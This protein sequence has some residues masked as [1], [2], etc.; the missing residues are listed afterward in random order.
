[1]MMKQVSDMDALNSHQAKSLRNAAR[2]T[3][4]GEIGGEEEM[5]AFVEATAVGVKVYNARAVHEAGV[6]LARGPEAM[7]TQKVIYPV[8]LGTGKSDKGHYNILQYRSADGK[9]TSVFD[10]KD[11]LL[12]EAAEAFVRGQWSKAASSPAAHA[13]R[14]ADAASKVRVQTQLDKARTRYISGFVGTDAQIKSQLKYM[15][16]P[17]EHIEGPLGKADAGGRRKVMFI[18]GDSAIAFST[19]IARAAKD[20]G[21]GFAAHL[22]PGK[23][24]SVVAKSTASK[25]QVQSQAVQGN[26]V[27]YLA[28][29]AGRPE[30]VREKLIANSVSLKGLMGKIGV[31]PKGAPLGR[32]RLRFSS[33]QRAVHFC[34]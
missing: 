31:A 15:D 1:H 29:V 12:V 20:S 28:G 9:V 7:E 25:P 23:P 32:R 19:A 10:C 8:Y 27:V 33:Q 6:L 11:T 34:K 3:L 5:N 26:V 16:V 30:N 21:G 24:S 18:L 2:R 14:K 13:L 4:A 17:V 22:S